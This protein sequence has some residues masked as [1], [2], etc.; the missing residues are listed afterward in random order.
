MKTLHPNA[1]KQYHQNF[2]ENSTNSWP[3]A[4]K[5]DGFLRTYAHTADLVLGAFFFAMRSCEYTKTAR[6][7]RTKRIQM[8]GIVF[9]T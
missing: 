9:R 6:P 3:V 2:Y 7:G 4:P 5:T 1:K 8:G